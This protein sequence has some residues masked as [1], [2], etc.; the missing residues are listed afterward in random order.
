VRPEAWERVKHEKERE[1]A[2]L[3]AE[4]A[5]PGQGRG[6]RLKVQAGAFYDRLGEPV[7]VY[8]EWTH[9]FDVMPDG[10]ADLAERKGRWL[11]VRD[12]Y[13][14]GPTKPV[15]AL[16]ADLAARLEEE[17]DTP[18]SLVNE[19]VAVLKD[20][21]RE[22]VTELWRELRA[23]ELV[24]DEV[25]EE[26]GEDAALPELREML[27]DTHDRLEKLHREAERF[28]GPFQ[29]SEPDGEGVARTRRLC[30]R[31]EEPRPGVLHVRDG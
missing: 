22:C 4:G 2:R 17:E 29:L 15:V 13:R 10:A 11:L 14:F 20:R 7:P 9:E 12:A 1:L 31:S 19:T 8:P 27:D 23:V 21:L 25:G 6:K 28:T 30:Y 24:V 3:V 26:F 16:P 5:L 18:A